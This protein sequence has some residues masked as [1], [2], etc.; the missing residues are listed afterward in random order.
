MMPM[1]PGGHGSFHIEF[2]YELLGHLGFLLEILSFM[3]TNIA[4]LR[5]VYILGNI[6]LILYAILALVWPHGVVILVWST[7]LILIN[8]VQLVRSCFRNRTALSDTD[9]ALWETFFP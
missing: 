7:V 1:L 8:V 3:F 5:I 2:G 6:S 9:A 4:H